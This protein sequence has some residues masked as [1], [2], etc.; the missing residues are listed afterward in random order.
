M[1]LRKMNSTTMRF[2]TIVIT[3]VQGIFQSGKRKINNLS[4]FISITN[5][6]AKENIFYF[7]VT[8]V[9]VT[10]KISRYIQLAILCK[11]AKI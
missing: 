8:H 6:D 3:I 2:L 10:L 7:E 11:T 4:V 5:F 1:K 9:K